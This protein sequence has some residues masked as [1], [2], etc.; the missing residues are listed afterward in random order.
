[1]GGKS[2]KERCDV[3]VLGGRRE[4]LVS[5]RER[6]CRERVRCTSCISITWPDLVKVEGG[7]G[8][9]VGDRVANPRRQGGNFVMRGEIVLDGSRASSEMG[10]DN[11]CFSNLI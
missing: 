3:A 8:G 11:C 5:L 7:G 10:G 2:N 9:G 4:S 1:M 6:G